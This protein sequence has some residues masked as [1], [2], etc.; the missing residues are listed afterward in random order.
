MYGFNAVIV[1]IVFTMEGGWGDRGEE[2]RERKG[3]EKG[4][5]VFSLALT[6][7]LSRPS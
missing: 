6:M 2:E 4:V 3:K 1:V 5:M 7:V